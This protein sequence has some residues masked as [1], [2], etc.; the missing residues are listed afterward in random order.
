MP[1]YRLFLRGEVFKGQMYDYSADRLPRVG[2]TIS[3][4]DSWAVEVEEASRTAHDGYYDGS[5]VGVLVRGGP[6][7]S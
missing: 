3:P 2:E 1:V 7:P 4:D 6:P 5:I